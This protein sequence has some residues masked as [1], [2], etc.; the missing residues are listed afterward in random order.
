MNRRRP[1]A[2]IAF[3]AAGLCFLVP[4][5]VWLGRYRMIERL[6][7]DDPLPQT[8][9]VVFGLVFMSSL[10]VCGGLGIFL[11]VVACRTLKRAPVDKG[12]DGQR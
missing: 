6:A 4:L 9:M 5:A 10:V 8:A 7:P 12:N 3:I 1:L 11:L 2:G